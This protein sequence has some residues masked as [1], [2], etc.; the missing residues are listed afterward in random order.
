M[1]NV[2]NNNESQLYLISVYIVT[3][4]NNGTGADPWS[5]SVRHRI[6]LLACRLQLCTVPTL[7]QLLQKCAPLMTACSP[8][9]YAESDMQS[10]QPVCCTCLRSW[11][12][13]LPTNTSL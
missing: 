10:I 4:N 2:L 6:L 1:E 7:S 11:K 3:L 9:A 5:P 13:E 12:T 8:H